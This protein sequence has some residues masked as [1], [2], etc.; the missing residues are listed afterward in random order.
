MDKNLE[1]QKL[2]KEWQNY[3]VENRRGEILAFVLVFTYGTLLA[4][5]NSIL[6]VPICGIGIMLYI[7]IDHIKT[8]WQIR[9]FS[10]NPI[11]V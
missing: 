8:R 7:H 10:N 5:I 4:T 2:Q 6:A 1:T 3:A 9:R 11:E